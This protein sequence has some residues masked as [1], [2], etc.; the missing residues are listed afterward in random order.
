MIRVVL[1]GGGNLATHLATAFAFNEQVT[2]VQVYNRTLASIKHLS[3]FCATTDKIEE[4]E[5]ADVTIISVSDAAIVEIA[6]RLNTNNG[7]LVHTSGSMSIDAL[8]SN[9]RAGVLYPIQ[10]FT[11]GKEI[12][13]KNIPVCIEA[14]ESIDLVLLEK[15]AAAISDNVYSMN[16]NQRKKVHIAAVFVNN[17]ANH[18]YTIG[19]DIC[20][21]N[22][23]PFEV[24][25]PIIEETAAKIKS[26]PPK[27]AQT[28]P[29][30]RKDLNTLALHTQELN[31]SQ[32]E[33]YTLL[34][35]AIIKNI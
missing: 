15:L 10:S 6:N 32:K 8:K 26:I 34:S 22:Q 29:A 17:F 20:V 11:K 19:E 25:F 30:S 5:Q 1:I 2:L 7:L 16:S 9:T 35:N 24:L 12:S 4:I 13:F 33:I 18:L 14:K 28:G 27:K 23:I 31:K 3:T 21:E